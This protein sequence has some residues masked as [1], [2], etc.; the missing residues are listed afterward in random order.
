MN[1]TTGREWREEFGLPEPGGE[2]FFS[3]KA[4][5]KT[6]PPESSQAH[7]VRRAFDLLKLDGVL[8]SDRAPLIY[9]KKVQRIDNSEIVRLHRTFWNH[10]GAPVL[11]LIAP[12]DVHVYSGLIRPEPQTDASGR[13]PRPVEHPG[14]A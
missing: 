2:T 1:P 9:F 12:D 7:V 11:V 13:I 14:R 6:A 3:S 8:C 5:L 10:G 4:D